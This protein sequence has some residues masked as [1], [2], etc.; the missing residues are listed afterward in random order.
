MVYPLSA[1]KSKTQTPDVKGGDPAAKLAG[2]PTTKWAGRSA[3][4]SADK[5]VENST[6]K[7]GGATK[8]TGGSLPDSFAGELKKALTR[9]GTPSRRNHSNETRAVASD[10]SDS[11]DQ[12]H[13]VGEYLAGEP[14]GVRDDP[15]EEFRDDAEYRDPGTEQE[16]PVR[17]KVVQSR[18]KGIARIG[19]EPAARDGANS[20]RAVLAEDANTIA[21]AAQAVQI[22]PES[23]GLIKNAK[24]ED[25]RADGAEPERLGRTASGTREVG[26]QVPGGRATGTREID[27]RA[28]VAGTSIANRG[29]KAGDASGKTSSRERISRVGGRSKREESRIGTQRSTEGSTEPAIKIVAPQTRLQGTET[30]TNQSSGLRDIVIELAA[31]GDANNDVSRQAVSTAR[32]EQLTSLAA[33]LRSDIPAEIVRQAHVMLRNSESAEIRLVIRPP[34]LGRVRIQL[35][36]DNG[37]IAGR[38]LVDNGSVRELVEQNLGHLQREFEEQGLQVGQFDVESRDDREASAGFGRHRDERSRRTAAAG[39]FD[40]NTARVDERY[41]DNLRVNIVA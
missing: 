14:A 32:A 41:Y 8:K 22:R 12:K 27:G 20:K 7:P 5:P 11:P 40:A 19:R 33:R 4:N 30:E 3:A 37:H 16:R 24:A 25:A 6:G 34:E 31:T 15:P 35:N 23:D 2:K 38:I 18:K 9:K 13:L 28:T 21:A 17:A 26:G 36:L 10:S 29:F 39:Q 1:L